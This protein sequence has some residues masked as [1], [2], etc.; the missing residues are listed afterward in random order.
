MASSS[1]S[2]LLHARCS[3]FDRMALPSATAV[4]ARAARRLLRS[5]ERTRDAAARRLHRPAA[6]SSSRGSRRATRRAVR[7]PP[8]PRRRELNVFTYRNYYNGGGVAIG[9]LTGDGLP[10]I[11]LTSNQGG[12]RSILNHG[13]VPLPRHHRRPPGSKTRTRLVDTGVTIADVNGDGR[14]D[15]YVCHAGQRASRSGA[16][17]SCGST[18]ALDADSVPHVQ[19]DGGAVRRR[20]R[21]LLDAGRLLRLR[22]RRRS[23]SVRHQ[24]LAA[25]GEQLR[26]R[27]TCATCA[28]S[29]AATS[30]I[31]TTA[32]TSPTSAARPASSAARSRSGSAS[33]SA[34]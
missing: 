29:T 1:R 15:I 22:P 10:E 16:R 6:G 34:T 28:T 14:L 27:A 3:T 9:D 18:R 17:T 30:C 21:G 25:A 32:G 12:P 5:G 33:S 7:E 4:V 31:A 23:R 24:Q 20:R 2:V 13:Q 11:V 26:P 19:G 8:R